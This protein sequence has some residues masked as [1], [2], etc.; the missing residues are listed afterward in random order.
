M[1]YKGIL[2]K[3]LFIATMIL[4]SIVF[5]SACGSA[6][7][8][9]SIQETSVSNTETISLSPATP[10]PTKYPEVTLKINSS[11]LTSFAP[12]FIAEAEGYFA[13]FGLKMD[14]LTFNKSTDAVPLMITGDLDVFAGSINAGILNV[15]R[16]ENNVKLVADKGH[17]TSGD[18]CTYL[19]LLVRK[20]LYESGKIT[21]PADLA[22][23]TIAS[24]ST[25]TSGYL[26]SS[27]LAQAGLTF[28]DVVLNDIPTAGYLDAFANKS[29]AV[30]VTPELHLSRI[31]NGGNAVLLA[32]GESL[33][34]AEQLGFIA[35]GKNLLVDHPDVGARF[36]AAYLK[37][38]R[39]YN[40]GKTERN[41]QIMADATGETIDTL[42][43]ACWAPINSDGSIDFSGVA[44]FQQW[45]ISQGQLE[46]PV[47]EE[48]A[49]DPRFLTA[50][51]ALLNP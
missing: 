46:A 30:I 37:G 47:T 15:L 5:I 26:L 36:L 4:L 6:T 42:R 3:T 17:I 31:L 7:T 41:L 2:M 40:E 39:Q 23:Q 45:S 50:A 18:N 21:G 16:Q 28:D 20:D 38:V 34:R 43:S 11:P 14:Y 13:E 32:G 44:G 48:Q 22:R 29:V 25:G 1:F 9:V 19:G 12:I 35:F 33:V 51:Q 49:Y 10:E 27:Y 24:T 8:P